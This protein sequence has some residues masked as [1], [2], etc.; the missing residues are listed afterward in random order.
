MSE[1]KENLIKSTCKE[2]GLTY[3]ELGEFIGYNGDTLNNMA[4]KSNDKLSLF[5]PKLLLC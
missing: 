2:L 1:K 3:K 5:Y 4:S